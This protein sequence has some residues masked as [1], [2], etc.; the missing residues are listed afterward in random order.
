ML[1]QQLL[2]IILYSSWHYGRVFH[3]N[4]KGNMDNNKAASRIFFIL[5]M[6]FCLYS[7]P[8]FFFAFALSKFVFDLYIII[9][10]SLTGPVSEVCKWDIR[11]SITGIVCWLIY[12]IG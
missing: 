4:Q 8:T 12:T 9:I 2:A 5:F 10:K 7:W 6:S 3:E 1:L 11:D